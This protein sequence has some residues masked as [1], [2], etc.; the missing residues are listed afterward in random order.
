[1]IQLSKSLIA[2]TGRAFAVVPEGAVEIR[3]DIEGGYGGEKLQELMELRK[4]AGDFLSG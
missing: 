1:M 3:D 4:K 2:C